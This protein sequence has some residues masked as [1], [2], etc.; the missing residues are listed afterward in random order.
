MAFT[1]QQEAYLKTIADAGLKAEAIAAKII[2]LDA[3]RASVQNNYLIPGQAHTKQS[4]AVAQA[5]IANDPA[6]LPIQAQLNALLN[7]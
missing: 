1:P 6:V 7:Q 4:L 5:A 3:A 2:E